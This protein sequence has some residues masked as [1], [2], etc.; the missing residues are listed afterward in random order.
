[1]SSLFTTVVQRP[2][3]GRSCRVTKDNVLDVVNHIHEIF[4]GKSL[5]SPTGIPIV[6]QGGTPVPLEE[7][8]YVV[9]SISNRSLAVFNSYIY[10]SMFQ[11]AEEVDFVEI[12]MP[13]IST[14]HDYIAIEDMA[15]PMLV[16]YLSDLIA[17]DVLR[18]SNDTVDPDIITVKKNKGPLEK[19]YTVKPLPGEEGTFCLYKVGE[20]VTKG[21]FYRDMEVEFYGK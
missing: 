4:P 19:S 10:D 3:L 14:E 12:G 13:D 17:R 16:E 6:Y 7:G 18:Y 15:K 9:Y 11:R 1:M 20:V 21:E 5:I 2:L 8:D